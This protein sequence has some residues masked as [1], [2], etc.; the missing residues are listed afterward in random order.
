MAD[1]DT[2]TR[3]AGDRVG[4]GH[5]RIEAADEDGLPSATRMAG[6]RHPKGVGMC[7]A[8]QDVEAVLHGQ[9]EG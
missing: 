3:I 2:E 8:K 5:P 7:Q 4:Q 9:V 1:A 6:D